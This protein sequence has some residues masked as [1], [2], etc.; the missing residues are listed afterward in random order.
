MLDM[1]KLEKMWIESYADLEQGTQPEMV[2]GKSRFTLL[3]NP[4]TISRKFQVEYTDSNLPNTNQQPR[5][6]RTKPEEFKLDILLDGT[7]VV[8]DSGFPGSA[9]LSVLEDSDN[10]VSAQIDTLKQF[11]Y[12]YEG[13]LHRPYYVKL[14]WGSAD[15]FFTGILTG[16]DIDYKLFRPDGKPIRAIVHLSLISATHPHQRVFK[17]GDRFALLTNSIYG[18]PN[19]YTDVARANNM[20]SFR[21]VAIGA[22]INFPPLQ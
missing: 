18:D 19:Y 8:K 3:M 4:E 22:T 7:G 9:L 13:D 14:C 2:N 16:L 5:Y 6:F 20:L 15:G 17:G 10:D 12:K 1:G 21:R 11:C